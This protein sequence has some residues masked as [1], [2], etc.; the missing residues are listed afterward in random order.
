MLECGAAS[1]HVGKI[2]AEIASGDHR[3]VVLTTLADIDDG[4]AGGAVM[5]LAD[6]RHIQTV[7]S[8]RAFCTLAKI[9]RADA[10]NEG[11]LAAELPSRHGL[12]GALA[13][14]AHDVFFAVQGLA[15][16]R[17]AIHVGRHVHIDAA[18]NGDGHEGLLS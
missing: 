16:L 4:D 5:I 13:A 1:F 11:H 6:E 12:V 18:D 2:D 15:R 8:K 7:G 9:I 3:D 14:K 17:Q 10:T